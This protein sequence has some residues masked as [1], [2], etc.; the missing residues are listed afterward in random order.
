MIE[1]TKVK[2][3]RRLRLLACKFAHF[4]DEDVVSRYCLYCGWRINFWEDPT[5]ETIN[6]LPEPRTDNPMPDIT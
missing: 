2:I 4:R 3:A 5:I 1:T 6:P